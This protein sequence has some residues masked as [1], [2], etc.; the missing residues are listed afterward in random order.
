MP[1]DIQT[2]RAESRMR[3]TRHLPLMLHA[4]PPR[5][6]PTFW[7]VLLVLTLQ[8]S[9]AAA[10]A[11]VD[12]EVKDASGRLASGQVTLTAGTVSKRCT[13]VGGRCSITIA[14]GTYQARL[15]PSSG[16]TVTKQVSVPASGSIRLLLQIPAP[17]AA[18]TPTTG[19]TKPPTTTQSQGTTPTNLRNLAAGQRLL[20]QGSVLDPSGRLA[21]ASVTLEQNGR[22]IGT[23]TCVGGRFAMYDLAAGTYRVVA[24]GA[25]GVRATANLTVTTALLRPT[26]RLAAP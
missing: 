26:L 20:V 23:T 14:A 4:L 8:T 18:P 5:F 25:N 17:T 9:F 7:A 22:A 10:D 15:I 12:V 2:T 19:T 3:L 16:T 24:T 6:A 13:T 1:F 21:N 11:R